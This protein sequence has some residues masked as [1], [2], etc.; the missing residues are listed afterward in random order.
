MFSSTDLSQNQNK[1][2]LCRSTEPCTATEKCEDTCTGQ[3]YKCIQLVN[4]NLLT[5]TNAS[6]IHEWYDDAPSFA[7]DMT[8]GQSLEQ[9]CAAFM[10]ATDQWFLLDLGKNVSIESIILRNPDQDGV[11]ERFTDLNLYIGNNGDN[12][13]LNSLCV[14]VQN[15]T[16]NLYGEYTCWYGSVLSGRYISAKIS[17]AKN[18]NFCNIEVF[19]AK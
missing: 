11:E 18:F 6:N 9:S 7:V 14:S 19:I 10:N 12:L 13:E 3:G 1:G 2:P 16:T 17:G 15:H 8:T 4:V 5:A